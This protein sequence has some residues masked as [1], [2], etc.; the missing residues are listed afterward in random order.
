M[1]GREMPPCLTGSVAISK[2]GWILELFHIKLLMVDW[3]EFVILGGGG[4]I[5]A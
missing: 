1:L 4:Q 3:R 2:R 5:V